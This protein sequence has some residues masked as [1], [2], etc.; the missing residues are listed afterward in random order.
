MS[1]QA[2]VGAF[3]LLALLM[4]FGIFYVITNFGTRYTGYRQGIHFQSAAGLHAG[5]L[6][7]FSGVT[8]GTVDSITLLPDN[9][10]D[11][12]LAINR[13]VDIPSTS[14]FLIQAPLTGDPSLIIVPP[15]PVKLPVG[16][17]GP[18]PTPIPV[19]PRTILPVEEQ[20][21]GTNTATIAD[22][23]EQGQGEIKRLD[24]LLDDLEKR[25]PKLMD[26]LQQTLTNANDLTVTAKTALTTMSTELQSSLSQASSNIVSLTATLNDTAKL[27]SKHIDS[28]VANLDTTSQALAVSMR[29]LESLASDPSLKANILATTKNIADTTESIAG[30]LKDMRS[31]TSDPQTRAQIKDTIANLD[32]TMQRANS[33]LGKFGGE[34]HVYGVDAG[35]T[36]YPV[37]SA[38]AAPG[39]AV[40]AVPDASVH[41][42]GTAPSGV[43]AADLNLKPRLA[44]IAENL[45]AIQT[46]I[47]GLSPQLSACCSS[48]YSADRGPITDMNAII[49]PKYKTSLMVGANNI[50]YD[51]TAN[52]ALLQSLSQS[53][54]VGGGILYSQP[55]VLGQFNSGLFGVEGRFYNLRLPDLD[56]YGNINVSKNLMLFAGERNLNHAD[57]RFTYGLQA[58]FP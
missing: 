34:S 57:K 47:S 46:R 9:T 32:A 11:V 42:T 22:L 20:P 19:L 7:Y 13:D 44:H 3:A 24:L 50:G 14:R 30:I 53:F 15:L 8:V 38:S 1:R 28:I 29:S 36:P 23:L 21:Q 55:G 37:P 48:L 16:Y 56:L 17:T 31:I 2:Q 52:V 25:E 39:A 18:T 43:T 41:A 4:L 33:L 54:R 45:I 5:A 35:A 51:T 58:Q 49:L 26:S 10:V 27:N 6:V 40:P 12:V